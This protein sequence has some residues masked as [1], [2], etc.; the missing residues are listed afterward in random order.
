MQKARLIIASTGLLGGLFSDY[1][2]TGI[3]FQAVFIAVAHI[4]AFDK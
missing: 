1:S 4:P 2:A 3:L